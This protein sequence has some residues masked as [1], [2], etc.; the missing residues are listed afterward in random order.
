MIG[1]TLGQA[2]VGK[3]KIPVAFGAEGDGEGGTG[4]GEG[5]T[6][7]VDIDQL[8][9]SPEVQAV[10]QARLDAETEGLK[11]KNSELI[12]KQKTLKEKLGNVEGLDI[13][14]LKTLQ[15]QMD[16]NEE[17]RLLSEGKTEE[18]VNRRVELLK[19]DYDQQIAALTGKIQEYD[20]LV[21]NKDDKL[22]E[23]VIDGTIREAYVGL[24]FEPAAMRECDSKCTRCVCHGRGW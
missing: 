8:M 1:K 19:K 22:R 20:G 17:L 16:E 6:G 14:R 2:H 21:K 3:V 15:K 13:E 9:Q 24:D 10:I 18:V 12:A 23:L 11:N 7:G 5:G 4:D